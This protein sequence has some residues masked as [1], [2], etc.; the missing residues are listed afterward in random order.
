MFFDVW[1]QGSQLEINVRLFNTISILSA[2]ES[3]IF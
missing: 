1:G 2:K 3:Y